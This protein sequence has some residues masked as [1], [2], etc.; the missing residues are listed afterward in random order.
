MGDDTGLYVATAV[1]IGVGALIAYYTGTLSGEWVLYL[2]VFAIGGGILFYLVK[3]QQ[4]AAIR[5]QLTDFHGQGL[6]GT[7][8][9]HDLWEDLQ[10]WAAEE[11][12]EMELVWDPHHTDVTTIAIP[13]DTP[14]VYLKSILTKVKGSGAE[15]HYVVEMET[16]H[17]IHDM[18]NDEDYEY[19]KENPFATV[20][21][22]QQYRFESMLDIMERREVK[23]Q[24]R[25]MSSGTLPGGYGTPAD[26]EI[27][28]KL[29]RLQ[30]QTDA[31]EADV[32]LDE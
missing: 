23:R 1:L 29:E 30:Q 10:D 12:R 8:A 26:S 25:K 2:G 13:F 15:M 27:K 7:K 11:P 9:T 17:V 18:H 4:L 28:E 32:D 16:G 19:D 24:L 3:S 31:G 20:P 5:A 14:V 6:D 22:V 21:F